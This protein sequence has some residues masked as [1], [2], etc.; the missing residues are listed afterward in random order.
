MPDG[1]R[2]LPGTGT[3]FPQKKVSN[4]LIKAGVRA[5]FICQGRDQA[6]RQSEALARE[7]MEL[8][9][10][11]SNEAGRMSVEVPPMRGSRGCSP[12]TNRVPWRAAVP[13][14][15]LIAQQLV[16]PCYF[17]TTPAGARR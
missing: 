17:A 2:R 8:V 9:A 15:R 6:L 13:G 14:R 7:C 4:M 3:A 16:S 11:L 5:L 1:R 12:S 10:E